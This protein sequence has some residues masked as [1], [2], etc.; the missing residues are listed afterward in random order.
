MSANFTDSLLRKIADLEKRIAAMERHE[1]VQLP[2]TPYYER[3]V[4]IAANLTGNAA[5]QPTP[6]DIQ[7]AG[8]L[9]F[10]SATD[11][12]VFCQWEIPDDWY[13]DDVYIEVDWAPYSAATSGTD[14]VKWD[15]DYRSIAEGETL[16][17][18]TLA[19][20]ST[21]DDADYSQYQ[22]KHARH[23][24]AFD[25]ANQPL[26]AQDHMYFEVRRDTAVANDFAGTVIVTAFEIIYNSTGFP[27]SN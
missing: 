5:N 21:T 2:S 7:S 27:T 22:T 8:G 14:T 11:Q 13:G 23:T 10:S 20:V 19:Q 25:D 6:N 17:N 9:V 4:Q 24:L 26:T 15:V 3:H 12:S 16:T 1:F 18:G